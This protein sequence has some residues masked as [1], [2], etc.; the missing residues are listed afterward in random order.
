MK[1]INQKKETFSN[2]H[3][4]SNNDLF[5]INGGTSEAGPVGEEDDDQDILPFYETPSV[6]TNPYARLNQN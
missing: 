1:K 6:S 5:S 3:K 4:L 2:F